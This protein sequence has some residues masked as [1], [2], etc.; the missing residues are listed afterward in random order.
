[1]DFR[2]TFDKIPEDFDKYRPRYQEEVF[3]EIITLCELGS[4]KKVLEIGPGTG[5]ATEPILKTGCDYTAIELGENFT[6]FMQDKFGSYNNFSI[7]NADFEQYVFDD[8]I[9]DLVYS[10]ATIQWIPE[11]TAFLKTYRALKPGGYLAIFMTYSDETSLNINLRSEIDKV[12][13]EHFR[14]KRRYNCKMEYKNALHYGFTNF[15]YKEWKSE[16]ILNAEEYISWISTSCEHITLEEPYKT[17]FYMGV[18]NAFM[19]AGNK[20]TVIDTIPLYLFQKPL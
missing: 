11:E 13:K 6:S 16:R 9:Y 12:Y 7:I 4:D 3:R 10:A 15:K 18:R 1:M 19:S 2:K 20:M 5:Q 14:V 17:N 8:N